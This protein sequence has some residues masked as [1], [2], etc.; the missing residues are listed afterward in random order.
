M[1]FRFS[2]LFQSLSQMTAPLERWER[3]TVPRAGGGGMLWVWVSAG[4]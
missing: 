4:A 2:P 3:E 1:Q